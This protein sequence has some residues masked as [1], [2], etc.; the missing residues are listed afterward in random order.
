MTR[1]PQL[2]RRYPVKVNLNLDG[3][4]LEPNIQFGFDF[5]GFPETS[6]EM[7]TA[8]ASF[9]NRIQNDDQEMNRQVFS[10]IILR[11]FSPQGSLNLG[12]GGGASVGQS[13]S[14]LLS[15]QLSYLVAQ[16]DQNLEIDF[17]LSGLDENA[18]N[19]FQLRLS[20]TLLNGRLRITR[21]GGVANMDNTVDATSIAGDWT[22]EYLLTEDG[23]YRVKIYNRNNFN[24][25]NR[26]L[27]NRVNTTGV[28]L[29]QTITFNSFNEFFNDLKKKKKEEN[30][31]SSMIMMSISEMKIK[32]VS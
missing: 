14:Q 16:I 22:A 3:P 30:R 13:L 6:T 18:L 7:Q 2:S 27:N 8:I 24:T 17:D 1:D 25:V 20:Y 28:S 32:K 19:T 4:L 5:S 29:L 10:V 26:S 15:N 21:D 9:K 11:R 12:G 23:K 31:G